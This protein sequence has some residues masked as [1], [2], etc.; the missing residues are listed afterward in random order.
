MRS[1]DD[2]EQSLITLEFNND[3]LLQSK[4]LSNR[5]VDDEENEFLLKW[6]K[7]FKIKD[8]RS[9]IEEYQRLEESND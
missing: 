3:T 8:H 9:D 1:I 4:G 6:M 7:K 2:P 5:H